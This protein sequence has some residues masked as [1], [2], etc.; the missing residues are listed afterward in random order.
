VLTQKVLVG[1]AAEQAA[2][3]GLVMATSEH[4]GVLL[5]IGQPGIGK[6]TLLEEG[7][8]AANAAGF[9][10]VRA[11]GV[12]TEAHL[13]FA[14]LH[15]LLRPLLDGVD[16]LPAPQ[17]AALMT[18][19]GLA[20]A[21]A[22]DPFLVSLASLT[23]LTDAAAD[24]PILAVVDDA[25]W[26]DRPTDEVLAFV[27]RRLGSDP[28]S[29][30]VASRR[31]TGGTRLE[32]AG[33]PTLA[34]E[35][36]DDAGA[37][38]L[39][40]TS[41][42]HLRAADRERVLREAA[43]NPLALVELAHSIE[44]AP[45]TNPADPLPLTARIEQAIGD[46]LVDLPGDTEQLLL[47][48]ALDDRCLVDDVLA[49]A[50][51]LGLQDARLLMVRPA[52]EARLV[53][54][55]SGAIRFRHPLIRSA[56][57]QRADD[58]AR[59]AAH[60]ALAGVVGDPDRAA[61]HLAAA[62]SGPDEAA[63]A[64]LEAAADRAADRGAI[65]VATTSLEKAAQL[66][67]DSATK[68]ARLLRAID[69]WFGMGRYDEIARLLADTGPFEAADLEARRR[70]W[71]LALRLDGPK[72]T[73]ERANI[74]A[75]VD[76]AARAAETDEPFARRLLLLATARSWWMDVDPDVW[77]RLLATAHAIAPNLDDP[78][79]LLARAAAR[80]EPA[81]V[82]DRLQR[83][84]LT[85]EPVEPDAARILGT[86]ALWAG[87][88]DAAIELLGFAATAHRTQGRVGLV[89]RG[90]VIVGWCALSLGRLFD[91]APALDEGLRLSLETGQ[92]NFAA[93]ATFGLTLY[94]ALRGELDR[95]AAM[96][97]D[98]ER[99][100]RQVYADGLLA[101]VQHARGMLE[102]AGGRPGDAFDSLRHLFEPGAEGH[103]QTISTWAIPEL[104]DAAI[105]AGRAAEAARCLEALE[106]AAIAGPWQQVTMAY[107]RAQLAGNGQDEA[108]AEAAFAEALAADLERWPLPR[109]RLLLAYG[110]WLRRQRRVA[111]S[112]DPLRSARDLF[113]AIGVPWLAD[114][115][116]QEL[117]AT[118]EGS[119]A[120]RLK[121]I[122][123]LTPQEMQIARLAADG[124][125][126]RQIGERLYLS[127]RTVG[128]HLYHVYPK[129]G[130]AGRAQ[131]HAALG[132]A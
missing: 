97:A 85:E 34:V 96:L 90:Q 4:G 129:L 41:D 113:D 95:G 68:G 115:A 59:R 118:G 64:Q 50:A 82:A 102:L 27:A 39:L 1:R 78:D 36:L 11:T 40:A 128:F 111:E 89:A 48:A 91:A 75:V 103:H 16:H 106:P 87:A 26:L 121:S 122:D 10:V 19:F 107:A 66:S 65:G 120:R 126:N 31:S 72:K 127:H 123:E 124:L 94:H 104:I 101:H 33:L 32:A 20:E 57:V 47:L 12:R 105:P 5:L 3:R 131:L 15:Q 42:G 109:A 92:E 52:V 112:R 14:G 2:I 7:V 24:R 86:A 38:E 125:S 60:G 63:A 69:L 43:G 29:V 77:S 9:R 132:A 130:I 6:S 88:L 53:T 110:T 70:A 62:T 98:A 114:R 116:R 28:V 93:S 55:E 44:R 23:L 71:Q 79:L 25:H 61:W 30:L 83:A 80:D 84:L 58:G 73:H 67:P 54:V 8:A 37:R 21:P 45:Q 22:P 74:V 76:A 49:A 119:L 56:I 17:R 108:A 46:R 100:G 35:P 51:A 18:A 13:P 99:H 117:G 81:E